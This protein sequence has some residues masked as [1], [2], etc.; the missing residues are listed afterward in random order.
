[1]NYRRWTL[2]GTVAAIVV[3]IWL[4]ES[5]RVM[6]PIVPSGSADLDLVTVEEK[7]QRYPEAKE[8]VGIAGYVNSPPFELADFIGEKVILIDIWTYS[9]INCQRTFPYLRDWWTKY[10]DDGLLI[11]GVHTPEFDFEKNEQ[12]VRTA[13]ANFEIGWPVVLDNDYATWRAYRNQYW[14]R[15]Y[16][17][18]VDGYIV[19]D[20]IGEGGYEETERRIQ[21]ALAELR[22]RKG[23][24]ELDEE[25]IGLEN[26][27]VE[28]G[29]VGTP[30][31]YL[32]AFRNRDYL[33]NAN[34][35]VAGRQTLSM[36]GNIERNL[37][38]L[39]GE[40]EFFDEFVRCVSDCHLRLRY[41]A[42]QVNIVAQ[43][44]G[45]SVRVAQDEADVASVPLRE[46]TLYQLI[47]DSAPG[48]HQLDLFF[49]PGQD[50]FTFTFG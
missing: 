14:P 43:G 37:V 5:N 20:H 7:A 48:E 28:R 36:P 3:V 35:S 17:I 6:G 25:R 19:Y 18:D 13:V 2:I 47:S 22:E 16:L 50:L 41:E 26:G 11:V 42:R 15:K 1:M 33:G 45:T 32:G 29:R 8:L 44:D 40:W 12:N 38:Y 30:E 4:I 9:C 24:D 46:P 39:S 23:M 49:E 21:G 31:I 27:D 34:H 10:E